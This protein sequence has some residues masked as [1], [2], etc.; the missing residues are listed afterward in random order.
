[1]RR[2]GEADD[3]PVNETARPGKGG[4]AT[5]AATGTGTVGNGAVTTLDGRQH[6][7]HGLARGYGAARQVPPTG[8]HGS[9]SIA[10]ERGVPVS[11][12]HGQSERRRERPDVQREDDVAEN[13]PITRPWDH[14]P[15]PESRSPE[16]LRE[17]PP[18]ILQGVV[19]AD[20]TAEGRGDVLGA[21]LALVASRLAL[22]GP[23][24]TI[25]MWRS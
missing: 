9:R 19:D 1:M 3:G 5:G 2:I 15:R 13:R 16:H 24:K 8:G 6:G 18:S 10:W 23:R 11:A 20:Q 7:R 22:P 21:A 4:A 17:N 25:G 12:T 14:D